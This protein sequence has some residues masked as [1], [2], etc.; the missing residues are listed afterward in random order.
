MSFS[1]FIKN[2]LNESE[3]NNNNNKYYFTD[4]STIRNKVIDS[5]MVSING[6]IILDGQI[7]IYCDVH[8]SIDKDYDY[9]TMFINCD[10]IFN[11]DYEDGEYIYNVIERNGMKLDNLKLFDDSTNSSEGNDSY[12][13]MV[14]EIKELFDNKKRLNSIIFDACEQWA[15]D[16]TS[17]INDAAELFWNNYDPY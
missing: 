11:V 7:S 9:E 17:E 5:P 3:N 8:A 10:A 6:F 1:S 14:K 12:N 15:S 2:K 13:K 16:H 4:K